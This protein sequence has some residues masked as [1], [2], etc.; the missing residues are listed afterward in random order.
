MPVAGEPGK[1]K[2]ELS[3]AKHFQAMHALR[4]ADINAWNRLGLYRFGEM[5]LSKNKRHNKRV[6][7]IPRIHGKTTT[8]TT[9]W[10]MWRLYKDPNL[11]ILLMSQT[12]DLARS[13]LR[14]I[15]TYYERIRD[16]KNDPYNCTPFLVLG[17]C[18][19]KLW[20]EDEIIIKTRKTPDKTPS[21]MIAG[22]DKGI[23]SQHFDIIK[24]DDI[25]GDKNTKTPGQIEN[26]KRAIYALSE[27]GDYF[28]DMHTEYDFNGTIWHYNDWYA[29]DVCRKL[30]DFYDVLI[31][32]CWDKKTHEPLFPEKY[33]KES[34]ET[35]KAEKLQGD[36]PLEWNCQWLNEPSDDETAIFPASMIQYYTDAPKHL[37]IGIFV[38]PAMSQ[39][40]WSCWTAIVPIGIDSHGRRYVLPYLRIKEK[41]PDQIIKAIHKMAVQ[42]YKPDGQEGLAYVGVEEGKE[43]NAMENK[44]RAYKWLPLGKLK[45][46][47]RS[48][49]G[50]I[51]ELQPLFANKQLFIHSSMGELKESLLTFPR[52]AERDVLDA[53]AYHMDIWPQWDKEPREHKDGFTD[54]NTR[55]WR[56]ARKGDNLRR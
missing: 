25:I 49:D 12:G 18:I 50:R 55:F 36:N 19:G 2:F 9:A 39:E 16:S 54:L 13:M 29:A 7:L 52:M 48:K 24:G 11:R 32:R 44:L 5:R 3:N 43:Y 47:G 8:G 17:D 14:E 40:K 33:T 38:D 53:V 22:I 46:K 21:I 31:M 51:F 26:T 23:A 37:T 42:Y 35:I 4:N 27:L 20:N 10:L 6:H 28:G 45:I 1:N 30:E 41:D 56:E 34:L 15:K